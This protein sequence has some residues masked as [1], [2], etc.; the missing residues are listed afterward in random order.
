MKLFVIGNGFDLYHGFE[1]GY[2]H[3]KI[4]LQNNSYPISNSFSLAEFFPEEDENLW[5]DFENK[6]DEVSYEDF[7]G[8]YSEDLTRDMSDKDWD[9]ACAVNRDLCEEYDEVIRNFKPCLCQAISDFVIE[10][11]KYDKKYKKVLFDKVFDN[12][13]FINFNYTK[14]LERIYEI[15]KDQILYIHGIAYNSCIEKDE[16]FIHSRLLVQM[17][18]GK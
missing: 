1:T 13:L 7:I 18:K 2:N 15:N 10:A 8:D 6:L 3:F 9:W 17:I 4:F 5:S 14:T 16:Y 12:S 11:V